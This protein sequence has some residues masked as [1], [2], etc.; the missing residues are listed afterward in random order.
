MIIPCRDNAEDLVLAVQSVLQQ[1]VDVEVVVV[2]DGSDPP[3]G[4]WADR[5][6]RLL[7][8]EVP[9]GPAAARNA[10]IRAARG[11]YLAFCDS[12]DR[13]AA[14]RLR[15]ALDLHAEAD[16]VVV[17]QAYSSSAGRAST[18]PRRLTDVL[19]STAP[20][21]GATSV[22][23]GRCPE[24]D[25]RFLGSEDQEWWVRLIGQSPTFRSSRALGYLVGESTRPRLLH[26]AAARL[27]F[28]YRLLEVH[29][30]Y[31]ARDRKARAFRWLRIATMER[32]EG[33]LSMAGLA[34]WGSLQAGCSSLLIK[35]TMRWAAAWFQ[36][37]SSPTEIGSLPLPPLTGTRAL[38]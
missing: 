29:S 1:D 22:R 30:D 15:V 4:A 13:F 5:R 33:N 12:D 18:P 20:S 28:S 19:H 10:G 36:R 14:G 26:S 9:L 3:L 31:F 17:A 6:V 34:L 16:V 32:R 7:R 25:Q 37:A 11:T 23:R 35:E 38:R 27:E 8:N 24:L 2:D 21:L